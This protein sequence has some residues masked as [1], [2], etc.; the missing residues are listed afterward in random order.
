ML[1]AVELKQTATIVAI[2]RLKRI[3]QVERLPVPVIFI[4]RFYVSTS[5]SIIKALINMHSFE[6]QLSPI[7]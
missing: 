5:K 2:D 4:P 1:P 6:I 3:D 7:G